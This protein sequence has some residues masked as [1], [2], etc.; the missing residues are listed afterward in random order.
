MIEVQNP[1][2]LPLIPDFAMFTEKP[3]EPA[4]NVIAYQHTLEHNR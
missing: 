3:E 4:S 2:K 1:Y